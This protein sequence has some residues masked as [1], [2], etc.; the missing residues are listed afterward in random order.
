MLTRTWLLSLLLTA[1]MVAPAFAVCPSSVQ[2]LD[3]LYCSSEID[4]FVDHTQPSYLGGE[5]ETN[6]CYACGEPFDEQAQIAPE[7]VYTFNCQVTGDVTLL[8]TNLPCDLDIYVLDDS[9]DPFTG[10]VE[11]STA[12]FAVDDS[13]TFTCTAG[14]T[15]YVVVEA[16]G[17]AHLDIASG[18]CTDPSGNVYSPDYT[19]SF[20]VSASTGCNEDCADGIDNDND[21]TIDCADPDCGGE[22]VCCDLDDDSYFAEDCGGPDCDDN[23]A[24]VYPGAPELEDGVDNDCDGAI[25]DGTDSYDDGDATDDDDS[26]ADDD[27]TAGELPDPDDIDLGEPD[28]FGCDCDSCGSNAAGGGTAPGVLGLLLLVGFRRF[29]TR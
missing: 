1:L 25:D 18:P 10:C 12:S 3:S 8:I 27:D 4:S 29:R 16:Y 13:V 15:H 6:D 26:G 21:S 19:L 17:T 2:I 14:A 20:D 5:C 23:D 24:T 22:D 11:G 28:T 7:A 9:C